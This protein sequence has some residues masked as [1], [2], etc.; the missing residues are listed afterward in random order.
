MKPARTSGTEMLGAREEREGLDGREGG[1]ERKE[2]EGKM[3]VE[4]EG[5]R[6][7]MKGGRE[8]SERRLEEVEEDF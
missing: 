5:E 8:R 7:R 3:R 4:K 6:E 2:K 1:E